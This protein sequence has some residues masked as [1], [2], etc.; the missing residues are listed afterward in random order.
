[1]SMMFYGQDDLRF[2]RRLV[3]GRFFG[4]VSGK[5]AKRPAVL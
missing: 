1:M 4:S 2:V 3:W 5:L